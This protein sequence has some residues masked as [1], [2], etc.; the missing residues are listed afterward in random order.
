MTLFACL[1]KCWCDPE[2]GT[3]K[4]AARKHELKHVQ[5]K[6]HTQ[7]KTTLK[8]Y[9]FLE[10]NL[11]K[12]VK[13]IFKKAKK[14]RGIYRRKFIYIPAHGTGSVNHRQDDCQKMDDSS[15][16]HQ[17]RTSVGS[18]MSSDDVG[19][20]EVRERSCHQ[21]DECWKVDG[22]WSKCEHAK[23]VG[24]SRFEYLRPPIQHTRRV[25]R[26]HTELQTEGRELANTA[27]VGDF[28]AVEIDDSEMDEDMPWC[29]LEVTAKSCKHGGILVPRTGDKDRT[30][31]GK[32]VPGAEY[33][34]GRMMIQPRGGINIF[35]RTD[36]NLYAFA[37]DVRVVKLRL[38]QYTRRTG[39][40]STQEQRKELL[41]LSTKEHQKILD[42][43]SA[44]E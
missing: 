4:I 37:E 25:T 14:G 17:V 12:P 8:L 7:M 10:E 16:A 6:R 32:L 40:A 44:D 21:C 24:A 1:G 27:E 35:E 39:R 18:D 38:D 43:L 33:I 11:R 28:V 9:E 26:A 19:V 36:W 5:G 13:D 41:H 31:M 23:I 2:G 20:L 22:D 3:W 34:E 30:W 15:K 29:I 42:M